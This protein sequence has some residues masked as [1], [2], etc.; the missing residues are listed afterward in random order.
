VQFTHFGFIAFLGNIDYG[1]TGLS[2]PLFYTKFRIVYILDRTTGRISEGW[3]RLILT[4]KERK[5]I[6]YYRSSLTR[7]VVLGTQT[8]TYNR[9]SS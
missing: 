9:M 3:L 2:S 7:K 8:A 1:D 5:T 6:G 4:N